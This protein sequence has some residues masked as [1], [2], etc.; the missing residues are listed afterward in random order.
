MHVRKLL[1]LQLYVLLAVAALHI[2]GTTLFLYW[3]FWWYDILVH[4]LASIWL[5]LLASWTS[6]MWGVPP[7]VWF[8]LGCVIV[9]SLG[10]EVF[11]FGIGATQWSAFFR[12]TSLDTAI[13][14]TINVIGGLVGLFLARRAQFT[15]I[16]K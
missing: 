6:A 9:V 7:R 12:E 2:V 13:D 11:E 3:T 4:F 16:S 5:G 8:V 10:W 14:I 1:F 15:G